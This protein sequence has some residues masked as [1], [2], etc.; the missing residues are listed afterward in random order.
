MEQQLTH[1]M[2]AAARSNRKRSKGK[3]G[4]RVTE[5]TVARMHD[6]PDEVCIAIKDDDTM[7]A[8]RGRVKV[9]LDG[10]TFHLVK[11]GSH[12][13]WVSAHQGADEEEF[14]TLFNILAQKL[15][16]N[17]YQGTVTIEE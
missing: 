15:N 7:K 17:V 8:H 2:V 6:Y 5:K 16:V 4:V 3:T 11:G 12:G 14:L 9:D 13:A 10:A 1:E